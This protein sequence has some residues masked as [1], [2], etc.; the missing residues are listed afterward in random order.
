MDLRLPTLPRLGLVLLILCPVSAQAQT[1]LPPDTMA[2]RVQ[3]CAACHG[4]QGQGT[5]NDYFP[6]LAGKPA[7]YLLNQLEAFHNGKRRYSPMNYLLE[8]LPDS[9]L[10][11]MAEYYATQR[12]PPLPPAPP[13]VSA[14]VLAKGEAIVRQG[15][16]DREIPACVS[17]HGK[18]LTGEEPAI[19]GLVGLHASYISAQ[20]GAFRYGTRTSKAPDCMQPVAAHL[21]EGDVAAVAAY[22]SSLPVPADPSPAPT[23]S[24]AMTK[25]CGAQQP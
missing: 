18:N 8:F 5:D 14:A 3:A 22:L 13:T 24:F 21:T 6:R 16:S 25:L 15:D 20:L 1:Q 23:S 2:A 19:P 4:A 11:R 9:Y 7:G 17:C 12:P 10:R